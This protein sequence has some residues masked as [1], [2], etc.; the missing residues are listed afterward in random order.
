[1]GLSIGLG[2]DR[3]SLDLG[4][5]TSSR[6][7]WNIPV[8]YAFGPHKIYFEYAHANDASNTVGNSA[9]NQW[10]LGYDYAFSKRTSAGMYYTKVSNNA[11]GSYDMFARGRYATTTLAGEDARQIYFGLAHNF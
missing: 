4:A 11:A 9:G 3:S 1:M 7:A 2:Y 8:N 5:A 6:T 10:M